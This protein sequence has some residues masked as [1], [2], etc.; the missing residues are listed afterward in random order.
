MGSILS[1]LLYH[2]AHFL[3][4]RF[5]LVEPEA[6]PTAPMH[7]LKELAQNFDL[8]AITLR[9]KQERAKRLREDGIKQFEQ[10]KG[11]FSRFKQEADGVKITR[12]PVTN[13][14]TTVLIV[15]A[16]F[17][18]LVT[19]V[20]LKQQG[21]DD[22]VILDKAAGFGGTWYWNQYPGTSHWNKISCNVFVTAWTLVLNHFPPPP[23][24]ACDVESYIYLPFLEE[25]GYMP[26]DR[27]SYGP[28]IIEHLGRVVSKWELEQH[29]F[30]Q[31]NAASIT[32]DEDSRRWHILTD[33]DDH[34]IAQF[35]V[36]ATGTLHEPKLPGI[37]GIEN[38]ERDQFHCGRWNYKIT[39]GDSTGKMTKLADKTVAVIGTGASAV[40]IVP[41]LAQDAKRLLVFQ[42]TP[43]S[44]TLR[45]NWKTDP[46]MQALLQPGWQTAQMETL[47][48]ILQGDLQDKECTALEGL[49]SVTMRAIYREAEKAGV[50]LKPEEIPE[51]MQL[52]DVR[53]MEEIRKLVDEIIDDPA[54]A[55]KLKPWYSFMCKRPAYSNDYL[56]TFNR[57]NVELIDTNGRGVSRLTRT[58]VIANDVEYDVDVLIYATGY[59]Y[60]LGHDLYSRTGIRLVGSKGQT[61]D[62]KWRESG[63]SSL[64][65]IHYRDF[66]NLF[67]I[68][69]VQSAVG[70]SWTHTTYVVGQHVAE[71]VAS[72]VGNPSFEVIEP[73]EDAEERWGKNMD[74]G[75]DMRL[76]FAQSCPPGYYNI[77]GK[78]ESFSS[79]W[80]MYPKGI[81]EWSRILADWR[82]ERSMEGMEKR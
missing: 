66:P 40:G 14:K 29:A 74:E 12:D 63:P 33:R 62:E 82:A 56:P 43:S 9:Y 8:D 2:S 49:E 65:G 10:A 64:F 60:F 25:T 30:L 79:R 20:K 4:S 69:V 26:K 24:V 73:T 59:D 36:L 54:T 52:A 38:F 19:A 42:R 3:R 70:V 47:A 5:Y 21:V 68:G 17:G 44:I 80:S 50:C 11:G 31:T 6:A 13:K 72:M 16:G 61:L 48:S 18:G 78:P 53:R 34:F 67:N 76:S 32:W 75:A 15:G 45:E 57:P 55:E 37:P 71:V 39:G 28:E 27:F 1:S 23:G 77:E 41:L 35:V 7:P 58:G 22:F 46:A 81:Q 51:L